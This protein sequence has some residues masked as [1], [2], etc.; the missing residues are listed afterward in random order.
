MTVQ[1][2]IPAGAT[3][4]RLLGSP[5]SGQQVINWQ[6]DFIT[7]G[8][9]GSQ[10]PNFPAPDTL[11]PSI[12]WYNEPLNSSNQNIGVVGVTNANQ[13]LAQ[14][15]GF[16]VW[17]GDALGG[18]AAFTI[19]LANGAP[20]IA[21]TPIT[22]PMTWTNNGHA[23]DG[24]NLVSNPLPS[25]IDFQAISR[26]ADV[27][28]YVTIYNPATGNSAV[29]DISIN[30]NSPGTNGATR[31]I[32]SS[33]AFFLKATGSAVTTTVEEA[34]KVETNL[35]GIFGMNE[36]VFGELRLSIS[37]AINTFSDE[38]L[39]VF[40]EGTPELDASDALK[41]VF[42][43]SAAPQIS[44]F[45]PTGESIAI[46]AYGNF[47]E[48]LAVP[49]AVDVAVTGTYTINLSEA[50]E[51]PFS[52]IT[53]E[54][55]QTGAVTVMNNG[56]SYSFT[57]NANDDAS[58]ARFILRS[59]APMA[60]SSADVLCG[61]V[62]DGSAT[63]EVG[64][65]AADVTWTDAFGNT[66]LEQLAATGTATIEGLDAGS[67][68]VRVNTNT[69]CG[70][71]VRGFT[72]NAP[73]VLEAQGSTS[74]A[75]CADNTGSI[76]LLVMGGVAPYTYEWSNGNDTEDL[77]AAPGSYTV[78]ITDANGCTWTSDALTIE[79]QGPDATIG[80]EN[81]LTTVN[82]PVVFTGSAADASYFWEFG[83]GSTSTDMVAEHAWALPGVYNVTLTVTTEN[84]TST[85]T[86]AVTVELNT[87]IGSSTA[88]ATRVW[89]TV[90]G[91]AIEHNY[92]GS[93]PLL[94][95]VLD[96]TGRLQLQRKLAAVPGR[97]V[98]GAENLSTGVWFVRLAQ[99]K[100]QETFRVPLMR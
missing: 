42:A 95:E 20:H 91:I 45:A 22:L 88:A 86:V 78:T 82:T 39:I 81:T 64:T 60:F 1:R 23:A 99:G 79:H 2:Y 31:Y 14:G 89:S 30:G 58:V 73:F 65:T 4:W 75:I 11:W 68:E 53:L 94:V 15:Q 100:A 63:V 19:D 41:Y 90:Q 12:R 48:A 37:S 72:I 83:D 50:G 8:Y 57:I 36:Q 5:I 54:D 25:P 38:A 24:W 26:G 40:H 93:E 85:S 67:Y 34:D 47:A 62:A 69:A 46:N 44:T 21:S 56:G 49:V 74:P 71:F 59:S 32:Q 55:T 16:A 17:C 52:C 87:G 7:A 29:Y 3:N 13:S 28:D 66:L 76:D 80:V 61:N 97:V 35:G 70:E 84:C 96:A 51:L 98:L 6:D 10:Y 33:Q 43:H 9:P 77:T 18:T 92:T 27:G